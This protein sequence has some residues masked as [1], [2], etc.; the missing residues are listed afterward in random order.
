M[1]VYS[2]VQSLMELPGIDSVQV[3]IRESVKRL[4]GYLIISEPVR[5]KPRHGEE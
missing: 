3:L 1:T 4:R 2:A 5:Q